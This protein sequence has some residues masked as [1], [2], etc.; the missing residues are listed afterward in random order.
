MV[1]NIPGYYYDEDKGK[2]FK[3]VPDWTSTAAWSKYSTTAIAKAEHQKI[4]LR[5]GDERQRQMRHQVQR[6]VI[7]R[8]HPL[9]RM[10]G[11]ERELGGH[12]GRIRSAS[13][14]VDIWATA[15]TRTP[16]IDWPGPDRP[17]NPMSIRHFIRDPAT[18]AVAY[19]L[20]YPGCRTHNAPE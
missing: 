11:L 5:K 19:S 13:A 12:E 3:I 10:L 15:L 14:V 16:L 9:G 20:D 4:E 17:S 6:S 8:H 2:Y 7:L 18:G 1:P